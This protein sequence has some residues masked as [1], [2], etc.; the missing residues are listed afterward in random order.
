MAESKSHVLI[1]GGGISGAA[2]AQ[3]LKRSNIPFHVYESDPT[4]TFRTQGY[5]FRI[6]GAGAEALRDVLP[7]ELFERFEK[8][9]TT[10]NLGGTNIDA[11]TRK[12]APM[13]SRGVRGPPGGPP[14]GPPN[15]KPRDLVFAA[16]RTVTR[17]VLLHDVA[18]SI[19]FGKRLERYETQDD[20]SVTAF[21]TDG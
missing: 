10:T 1:I 20:S 5:R 4:P 12:L 3:G 17:N 14:R 21:F 15:S 11:L 16:D 9:C 6:A 2:L 13:S 8:I 7:A 19:T 18:G